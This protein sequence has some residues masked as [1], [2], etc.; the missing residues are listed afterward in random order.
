MSYYLLEETMRPCEAGDLQGRTG[1]QY[2]AVL[3]T[4]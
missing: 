1:S 2:V 3:T 4:P